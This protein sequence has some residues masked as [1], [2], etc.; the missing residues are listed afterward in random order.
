[1]VPMNVIFV[2]S[3]TAEKL[4]LRMQFSANQKVVSRRPQISQYKAKLIFTCKLGK[5]P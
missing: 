5:S 1:M 3:D 2:R 4:D